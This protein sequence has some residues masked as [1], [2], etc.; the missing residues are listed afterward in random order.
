[1]V[2]MA[3]QM[4]ATRWVVVVPLLYPQ[5]RQAPGLAETLA[6][7]LVQAGTAGQLTFEVKVDNRRWQ[8]VVS[9]P[10]EAAAA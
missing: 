5:W 7:L 3:M 8:Q 1:M 6:N 10:M 9:I 4:A 2:A